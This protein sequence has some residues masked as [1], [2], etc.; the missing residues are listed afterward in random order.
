[1]IFKSL[2]LLCT[3]LVPLSLLSLIFSLK[4]TKTLIYSTEDSLNSSVGAY[5]TQIEQKLRTSDYL[6]TTLFDNNESFLKLLNGSDDWHDILYSHKLTHAMNQALVNSHACDALFLY[7]PGE[8]NLISADYVRFVDGVNVGHLSKDSLRNLMDAPEYTNG[9]WNLYEED[10]T[11]YLLRINNLVDYSVGACVNLTASL[12]LSTTGLSHYDAIPSFSEIIPENSN[13]YQWFSAKI[14]PSKVYLCA[15]IPFFSTYRSVFF[16][17]LASFL[18]F[19]FS[20]LAIPVITLSFRKY[21]NHP[22]E[23]LRTAFRELEKGNEDYRITSRA[24]SQEFEETFASFNKMAHNTAML[25]QQSLEEERQRHE[26][27][28]KFDKEID[29]IREYLTI[30]SFRNQD[31]FTV[32]YQ[33]DPM[34][35]FL[36]VPPLLLHNFVKNIIKHAL[37]P[38]Q[39]IHIILYGEY[40]DDEKLATIQ[41]SDDG[42]GIPEDFVRRINTKDFSDIKPGQHVGIRN[43]I[44]RLDH[45]FNGQASLQASSSDAG[46]T[47]I[48]IKIPC[49]FSEETDDETD[50]E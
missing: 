17:I 4:T 45:Y 41:I 49:N 42:R 36:R 6:L 25:K 28:E 10:G 2:L 20:L 47:I 48:T 30:C 19:V 35:S 7:L 50:E 18:L 23:E 8:N 38:G 39:T 44:R 16:W 12:S 29:L 1:M 11:Q 15:E 21:I 46:G 14:A 5:S 3:I 43:S 24:S 26:M 34:L 31:A 37:I 33:L 32:S 13:G 27:T 9:K 22:L 40:D